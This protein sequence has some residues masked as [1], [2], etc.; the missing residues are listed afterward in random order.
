M[1]KL[2]SWFYRTN[3]GLVAAPVFICIAEVYQV[4]GRISGFALSKKKISRGRSETR[5]DSVIT[6]CFGLTPADK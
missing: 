6:P 4:E 3:C 2:I 1:G 5:P